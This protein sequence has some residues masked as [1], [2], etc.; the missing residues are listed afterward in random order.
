VV[1]IPEHGSLPAEVIHC[2]R[3]GLASKHASIAWS[4]NLV[5]TGEAALAQ[6]STSNVRAAREVAIP[7]PGLLNVFAIPNP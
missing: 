2:I 6:K 3:R 1:Q 4:K 5:N 7:N